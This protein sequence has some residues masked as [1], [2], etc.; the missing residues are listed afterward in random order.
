MWK[1]IRN[2]YRLKRAQ[3]LLGLMDPEKQRI[4]R[5]ALKLDVEKRDE[6]QRASGSSRGEMPS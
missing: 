1:A 2:W 3:G 6:S 5:A 4:V